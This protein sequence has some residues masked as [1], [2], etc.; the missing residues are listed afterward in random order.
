MFAVFHGG[1]ENCA[2]NSQGVGAAHW[3]RFPP[4]IQ[5]AYTEG[6][7]PGLQAEPGMN[8]KGGTTARAVPSG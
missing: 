5:L 4:G 8:P 2:S 6:G 1:R 3:A 7:N